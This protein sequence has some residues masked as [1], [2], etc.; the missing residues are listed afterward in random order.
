MYIEIQHSEEEV[1]VHGANSRT[2]VP[3]EQSVIELYKNKITIRN[4]NLRMGSDTVYYKT[5]ED[6]KNDY[7]SILHQAEYIKSLKGNAYEE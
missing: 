4:K 7:I 1:D 5:E 3:V 2:I 6:A